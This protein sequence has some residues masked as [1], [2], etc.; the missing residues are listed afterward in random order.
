MFRTEIAVSEWSSE[1]TSLCA[2]RQ[3]RILM[4]IWPCLKENGILIYSTCTFNSGE[5]EENIRWLTGRHQAECIRL[6]LKSFEGIM[7]IDYHGIYGYGFFPDKV[8]GEGFFISAI[9]K[10]GITE[11]IYPGNNR[12]PV[13]RPGKS[14][15]EV[16][17]AWTDCKSE[18]ILKWGEEIIALP[19]NL[20]E[21]T[22][23]Y[24]NLKVIKAG[25]RISV[26]KK[27]DDIPSHELALSIRLKKDSF[28]V[29]EISLNEAISF[30]RRDNFNVNNIPK[31]WNI[32]TFN[33]INLGFVKNIGSRINNYFPVEW[34]IRLDVSAMRQANLISWL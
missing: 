16:V 20:E 2:D 33:G 7:E 3:K 21:Y 14:D 17:S 6:D 31:G 9:R 30:L 28:P 8:R 29:Q 5:N 25:T 27:D 23:L 19:C 12:M 4:D 26:R 13:L 15:L 1:N 34:R 32:L 10:K 11:Y 22:Y 18:R 24:K